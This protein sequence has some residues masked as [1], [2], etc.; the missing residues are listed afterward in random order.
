MFEQRVDLPGQEAILRPK[1]PNRA[2]VDTG[3]AAILKAEP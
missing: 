2:A 1:Q 3:D